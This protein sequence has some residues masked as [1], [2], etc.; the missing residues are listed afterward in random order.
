MATASLFVPLKASN[1]A[2][3]TVHR[4]IV[5]AS[6]VAHVD[7]ALAGA[8]G[9]VRVIVQASDVAA[10]ELAVRAAGGKIT[11]EL[12]IASGFAAT[13]PASTIAD[14]ATRS[15]ISS[16]SLDAKVHVLGA[17][18]PS[19]VRSVYPKVVNADKMWADGT[20]GNGITVAL[21]D[22]GVANV[23]DLAGR[24]VP[25][26]TGL[27]GQTDPCVNFSG[28]SN[29]ND[30]YGHGTFIAGIIAGSGASSNGAYPGIAPGAKIVSVKIAGANGA[31]DVSNVLAAIQWV[32][33]YKDTYGIKVL[34]LSL[35]TD[36][37]QTYRTDPF[38]YAVERAWD[39]G[40]VVVVSAG[41][42]GPNAQTIS[43]PADDPLVIT[44]GATDDMATPG[45][46][47]DEIPNYSAHGPTA[48]D[49][50]VKPDLVAPGSHIVSLRAPGSTVD[51]LFP[52]YVDANYRKGSGTSMAA[53]VVSGSVALLLQAR[54][55]WTPDRIK[56]ALTSTANNVVGSDP[57][58]VGAGELN[59]DAARNAAT[60]LDNQGVDR[61]N[62]LGP[63]DASRGTVQ[64][65]VDQTTLLDGL[66]TAQLLLFSNLTY[67]TGSWNPITW[68]ISQ[69]SGGQWHGGQW[70][71]YDF[72][73]GQWHGGQWHGGQWHGGFDDNSTSYGASTS[74]G[75]WLGAWE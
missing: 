25:V 41:N 17:P 57:N 27:L 70:H 64:I 23:A 75:Q 12:P 59:I 9:R 8:T 10:A 68:Q 53:G 33:S 39:A 2:L 73:G 54:P 37:S 45:L 36:S 24:I 15:A 67:V 38:D 28:D 52:S 32:V 30:N 74:G 14:L 56:Y 46:G 29:C 40:I 16:I 1:I 72:S 18:D 35:G 11:R 69:W 47:D 43:K 21:V 66:L 19:K 26:K 13:L 62:G 48:A 55:T 6:H 4:D 7:P 65:D 22:T 49:G 44:V 58:T 61:S 31:T 50:L 42:A 3:P 60:G 20:N 34:N 63:I 5:V 51:T 71:E